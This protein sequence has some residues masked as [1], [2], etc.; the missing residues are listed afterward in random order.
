MAHN[1]PEMV[2]CQA[3]GNRATKETA[4]K[5]GWKFIQKASGPQ[6][7]MMVRCNECLAGAKPAGKAKSKKR[8]KHAI[9]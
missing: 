2:Q 6:G 9:P 5:S 8:G 1:N 4:I 3:C 7:N